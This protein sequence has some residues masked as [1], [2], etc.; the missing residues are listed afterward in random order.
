LA[1]LSRLQ[2]MQLDATRSRRMPLVVGYTWDGSRQFGTYLAWSRG[3]RHQ[4]S[5]KAAAMRVLAMSSPSSRHL[6]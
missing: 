4:A 5:R 1:S 2:L 3:V 6:A